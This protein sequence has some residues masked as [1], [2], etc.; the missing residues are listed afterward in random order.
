MD[1]TD[2]MFSSRLILR[3]IPHSFSESPQQAWVSAAHRVTC[4]LTSSIFAFLPCLSFLIFFLCFLR[5]PPKINHMYPNPFL[6]ARFLR[7][8]SQKKKERKKETTIF[9]VRTGFD[10]NVHSQVEFFQFE[11]HIW[12]QTQKNKH[13]PHSKLR[14]ARHSNADGPVTWWILVGC[15]Q[16]PY[17]RCLDSQC[18]DKISFP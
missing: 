11:W 12:K 15:F 5:L 13:Y 18:K 1:I 17:R 3:H 2:S 6:R 8:G 14:S 16:K 4:S 10:S 9:S 7:T